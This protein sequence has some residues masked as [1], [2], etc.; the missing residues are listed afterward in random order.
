MRKLLTHLDAI[1]RGRF[2]AILP[3]LGCSSSAHCRF[4]PSLG[5][6][7]SDE[8]ERPPPAASGGIT[9]GSDG[10]R[11]PISIGSGATVEGP[12]EARRPDS[13]GSEVTIKG[14]DRA[15]GLIPPAPGASPP[16]PV[17]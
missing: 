6:E 3:N 11:R 7:G 15:G 14:P 9:E 13:A 12:D 10:A 4:E 17:S 16:P 1:I 8:L 5:L 2:G